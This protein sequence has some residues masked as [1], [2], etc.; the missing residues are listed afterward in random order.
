M[1]RDDERLSGCYP[2]GRGVQGA[3]AGE[4]AAE[5][6]STAAVLEY[7]IGER[8]GL[9]AAARARWEGVF[10]E[11]FDGRAA[12]CTRDA[13]RFAAGMRRAADQLDELAR[14]AREEQQRRVQAREWVASQQREGWFER[15]IRDPLFGE[16]D[17]PPPPPPV[18][19]PRIAIAAAP[20]ARG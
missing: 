3:A 19:P 7:Q 20:S 6:R 16:D 14:L 13:Q 18:D 4:L 12:I 8:R 1:V 17:L 2:G 11:Q 9:G 5:L 15:N 10:A